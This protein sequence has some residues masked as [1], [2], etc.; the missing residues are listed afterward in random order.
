MVMTNLETVR[1]SH[2][3]SNETH[4]DASPITHADVVH[5]R[6]PDECL[7]LVF[8]HLHDIRTLRNLVHV[9][10]FSFHT[11]LPLFI[12]AYMRISHYA[13]LCIS[14]LSVDKQENDLTIFVLVSILHY[15]RRRSYSPDFRQHTAAKTQP[16]T[17]RAR[18]LPV[19]ARLPPRRASTDRRLLSLLIDALPAAKNTLH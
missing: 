4:F 15:Q 16:P 7:R 19:R 5:Q 8:K 3:A 10:R 13:M 9:G 12:D 14:P 6:L 1:S 11:A 17:G 2:N 18:H